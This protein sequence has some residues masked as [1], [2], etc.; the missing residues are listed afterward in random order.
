MPGRGGAVRV[1]ADGEEGRVAEV[2]EPREADDDVEPEREEHVRVRV[3]GGVD[4]SPAGQRRTGT[5]APAAGA[6]PT[7]SGAGAPAAPPASAPSRTTTEERAHGRVRPSGGVHAEEAGR[8]ED[9]HGDQDR[10][11]DDVRPLDAE[12]LSAERLDEP[13][14]QRAGHGARDVADPPENRG[15]EGAEPGLVADVERGEA[16]VEAEEEAPRPGQRRAQEEREDDHPVDV[17][18]H[19]LRRVHVLGGRAHRL[20]EGGALHQVV[21]HQHQDEAGDRQENLRQR[22]LGLAERPPPVRDDPGKGLGLGSPDHQDH[23]DQDERDADRGDHRRRPRH[24][25]DR[26]EADPLDQDAESRR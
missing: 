14:D 11:D 20:A 17:H 23:V 3:R 19:H 18:A 12:E 21:Q 24:P 13:D 2:E 25:A 8:P 9:H 6:G 16:V 4:V 22:D 1:G 7:R 10:E 26:A 15:G 5:R